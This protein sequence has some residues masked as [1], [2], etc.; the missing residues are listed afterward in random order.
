MYGPRQRPDLAIHAFARRILA[1]SPIPMFGD[2]S[3]RRDYTF[4]ADVVQGVL[5]ALAYDRTPYEVL[6]LGNDRTIT[7][8]RMIGELERALGARAIIERLPEQPGD[9]PQTWA[10]VTRRANCLAISRRPG[11]RTASTAS[12]SGCEPSRLT[13]PHPQPQRPRA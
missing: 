2:G 10:A 3:T 11:S 7:L 6:N 12:S 4:V 5:G 13:K 1:G 8:T 9:V